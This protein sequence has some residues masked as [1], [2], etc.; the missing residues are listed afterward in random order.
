M[1]DINIDTEHLREAA[2]RHGAAAEQLAEVPQSHDAIQQSLD[3]LGPIFAE[4]REAGRALLEQRRASYEQQ[5]SDH[6][7]MARHLEHAAV[8]WE[9]DEDERARRIQAVHDDP[10]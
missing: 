8:T 10:A 4:L 3:S 1:M 2:R 9:A 6:A 7:D 5:A